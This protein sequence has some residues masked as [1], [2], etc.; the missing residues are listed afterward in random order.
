MSITVA[1][2]PEKCGKC[3]FGKPTGNAIM[4]N[5]HHFIGS[6]VYRSNTADEC[7]SCQM[8]KFHMIHD[9]LDGLQDL[10]LNSV[11]KPKIDKT[12]LTRSTKIKEIDKIL[13]N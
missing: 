5:S 9:T 11:A 4:I 2:L 8:L 10:A 13:Q 3:R 6:H 12:R 1:I 7:K